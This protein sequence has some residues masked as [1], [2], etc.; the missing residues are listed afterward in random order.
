LL[1]TSIPITEINSLS[2][3]SHLALGAAGGPKTTVEDTSPSLE[4]LLMEKR[5]AYLRFSKQL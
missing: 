3:E 1:E 4:S 2:I 5:K